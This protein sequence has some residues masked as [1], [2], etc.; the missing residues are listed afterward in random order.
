MRW[1]GS[2]RMTSDDRTVLYSGHEEH[3]VRGVGIVLN[4]K[5]ASALI[6]RKPVSDRIITARF[7]LPQVKTTVILQV[8][9][10][11]EDALTALRCRS[12]FEGYY[13]YYYMR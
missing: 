7:Q 6:G 4:K 2:G 11:T 5:A 13:Y 9:A 10:P 1:T 12:D 3:H 8:H